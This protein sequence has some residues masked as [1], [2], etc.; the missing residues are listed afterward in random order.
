MAGKFVEAKEPPTGSKAV[1]VASMVEQ[2]ID[3]KQPVPFE[4]LCEEAGAKYPQDVVAAMHALE[5]V[6]AVT[7]YSFVESG[8]TRKRYAYSLSKAVKVK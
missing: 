4:D 8:S 7:R 6:G 1:Q 3:A 2:L 5:C